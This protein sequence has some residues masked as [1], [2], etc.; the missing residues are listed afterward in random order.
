MKELA[1]QVV[2]VIEHN[3]NTYVT[4]SKFPITWS[5]EHDG[6]EIDFEIDVLEQDDERIHLIVSVSDGYLSAFFPV[7]RSTIVRK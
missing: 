2:S 6:Q 4:E 7:S 1:D 3:P 5:E